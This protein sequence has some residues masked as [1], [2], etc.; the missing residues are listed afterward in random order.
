[1]LKDYAW[2]GLAEKTGPRDVGQ[3]LA[4]GFGLYDM[5]G[6]IQEWCFDWHESEFYR[7]SPGVDPVC[8]DKERKTATGRV[9]RGGWWHRNPT[10]LRSAA[11]SYGPMSYRQYGFRVVVVGDLNAK[12]PPI[13]VA[14]QEPLPPT[15]KNSIGMEFA[16]V[17][18]GKS[19]LGGGKDKLGDREVEIPA[20]FYLGKYEVTQEEW[21][22]VMGENPSHFSRN[23][24]GKDAVKDINDADLKRFPI[25]NVTWDQ[26]Q[27]FVAKLNKLEK[28]MGWV[29]QLPT[30]NEWEYA[31]RGGPMLDKLD[32]AFDFY[33]TKPKN[34]LLPEQANFNNGV[35]RTCKVGSYQPNAL[36][37]YDMHGNVWEWCDDMLQ[38]GGQRL[39]RGGAWADH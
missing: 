36:G 6:N 11:R 14:K 19:W 23:G 32:G 9:V 26:C 25:E 2:Y 30:R 1:M 39:R 29:Y 10:S 31:C 38:P 34:T 24:D 22:Q 4:N 35:K 37:L 7:E 12:T 8:T 5:H 28:E 13:D 3:K 27:L 21:T 15:H 33:F 17:P 18:K 16:I 20:D